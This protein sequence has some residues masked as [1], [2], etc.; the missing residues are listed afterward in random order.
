MWYDLNDL[1]AIGWMMGMI[2]KIVGNLTC[3][4]FLFKP[5]TQ[6]KDEYIKRLEKRLEGKQ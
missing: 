5:V 2:G 6:L 1:W 4:L 3:Y